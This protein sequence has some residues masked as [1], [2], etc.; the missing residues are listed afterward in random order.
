MR[1]RSSRVVAVAFALAG[2]GAAT[3]AV[4]AAPAAASTHIRTITYNDTC[5]YSVLGQTGS[6]SYPVTVAATA[7]A[8]VVHGTKVTLTGVQFSVTIPASL[9]QKAIS[10]GATAIISPSKVTKLYIN[11][12]DTIST[13][14]KVNV[15]RTA[16]TIPQITLA[17]YKTTGYTLKVPAAPASKSGWIGAAAGTMNFYPGIAALSLTFQDSI[18]GTA[19]ATVT[20]KAL[21]KTTIIATTKVT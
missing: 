6:N 16:F 5:T 17:N 18:V 12:T 10:Y 15:T 20:C 2:T 9:I 21:P 8:S 7:P 4:A 11:A 3:L 1:S 19:T 14:S 13:A